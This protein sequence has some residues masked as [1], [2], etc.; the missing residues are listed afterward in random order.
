MSIALIPEGQPSRPTL[1]LGAG[2]GQGRT[3]IVLGR[4]TECQ[5]QDIMCSREHM[6]VTAAGNGFF[7]ENPTAHR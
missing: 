2:K 5:I 7:F 3:F 6:K 4:T 1:Q